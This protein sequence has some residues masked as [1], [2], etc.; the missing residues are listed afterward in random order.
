[1]VSRHRAVNL[2]SVDR[3]ERGR[4]VAGK[5]ANA[6]ALNCLPLVSEADSQLWRREDLELSAGQ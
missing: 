1:M 5:A 3:I 2:A 6:V 4:R